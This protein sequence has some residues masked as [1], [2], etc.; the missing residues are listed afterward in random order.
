[1]TAEAAYNFPIA[2]RHRSIR[3]S[4]SASRALQLGLVLTCIACDVEHG[5]DPNDVAYEDAALPASIAA[6][7][8]PA[9][10]HCHGETPRFGAPMPLTRSEHFQRAASSDPARN[11]GELVMERVLDVARPMPPAPYPMLDAGQQR[12]LRT[13]IADGSPGSAL[14]TRDWSAAAG[15]A[16]PAQP[17]PSAAPPP[18]LDCARE[19]H[20]QAHG[21]ALSDDGAPYEL[22][23]PADTVECFIFAAPAD[24]PVQA[25]A[26]DPIVDNAQVVHHIA[27]SAVEALGDGTFDGKIGCD[28]HAERGTDLIAVWTPGSGSLRM[29]DGVGLRL[30]RGGSGFYRLQ[31]HYSS[32]LPTAEDRS[33]FRICGSAELQA[34]EATVHWLGSERILV[35]P[36]ASYE[37]DVE[38]TVQGDEPVHVI[39]LLPHMHA[40]GRRMSVERIGGSAA[41]ELLHDEPFSFFNQV[42]YRTDWTLQPGEGLRTTCYFDN[43]T[44]L[45]VPFGL[46]SYTEMC[47]GFAIAYPAGRLR[48]PTAS[49]PQDGCVRRAFD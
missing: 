2:S 24:G 17:A 35:R 40:L 5:A 42:A 3:F 37:T 14:L 21:H 49:W 38:C 4:H 1:M 39:G 9:C 33:G 44:S 32:F 28:L 46:Q 36:G 31:V 22:A 6:V 15:A 27:L 25:L 48:D 30:P 47:Y 7:V 8:G 26:L 11:V 12:T 10:Q 18:A 29:P 13:W 20:L 16:A 41:G 23:G 43:P 45:T 34:Q 19:L